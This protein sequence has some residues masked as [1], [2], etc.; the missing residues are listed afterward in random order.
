MTYPRRCVILFVGM[1]T[2]L[3]GCG[4]HLR[5]APDSNI[6]KNHFIFLETNLPHSDLTNEVR[7]IF[8]TNGYRF[9]THPFSADWVLQINELADSS[10]YTPV[11]DRQTPDAKPVAVTIY[12][13]VKD[14][15]DRKVTGY[16]KLSVTQTIHE[17][18]IND[19]AS[20]SQ[21]KQTLANL[22]KDIAQQL[23]QQVTS[24]LMRQ[25]ISDLQKRI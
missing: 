9:T 22:H 23:F 15:F 10:P 12:Y 17:T 5:T 21:R 24:R 11:A 13:L 3:M 8:E 4:F 20:Q 14:N 1:I 25:V 16:R 6:P 7:Q 18:G 2:M 19:A